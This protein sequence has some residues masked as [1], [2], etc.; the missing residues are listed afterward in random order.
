VVMEKNSQGV[1]ARPHIRP[2]LWFDIRLCKSPFM[3][4][5]SNLV[6]YN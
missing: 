6:I 4:L 2:N 1:P 3:I 5:K